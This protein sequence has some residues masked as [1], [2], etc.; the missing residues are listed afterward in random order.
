MPLINLIKPMKSVLLLL[1]NIRPKFVKPSDWIKEHSK[2]CYCSDNIIRWA[3]LC[4]FTADDYVLVAPVPPD[5]LRKAGVALLQH[6]PDRISWLREKKYLTLIDLIDQYHRL[7]LPINY[8]K[9]CGWAGPN[10]RFCFPGASFIFFFSCIYRIFRSSEAFLNSK[11]ILRITT[12]QC[13]PI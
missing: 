10:P 2:M 6:I 8:S 1:L 13:N 11:R 9:L 3:N 4:T 5:V 12:C 7:I